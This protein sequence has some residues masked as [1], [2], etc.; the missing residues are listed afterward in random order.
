[1]TSLRGVHLIFIAASIG[2]ALM[3]SVWG[4]GM[5]MSEQ[6]VWGHLA[7]A[8]GSLLSAIA[9]GIYLAFFIRKTREIGME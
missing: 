3:V 4:T 8:A 6:G 7:F 5:Y 2:L 9:L 1:M